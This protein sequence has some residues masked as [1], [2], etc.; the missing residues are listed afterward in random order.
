MV[1]KASTQALIRCPSCGI[2]F[3][4]NAEIT[5]RIREEA[6]KQL[7]HKVRQEL[8]E[9]TEQRVRKEFERDL[10]EKDEELAAKDKKLK[11]VEQKLRDA[12]RKAG[13]APAQEL[14]V[15]R[16]ATL[17]EVLTGRC[18]GDAFEPIASGRRG[19]DLLQRVRSSGSE[20]CGL[21]L[22][23]S[24]RGYRSWSVGWVRKLKT[25]QRREGAH[26]AVIVSDVLPPDAGSSFLPIDGVFAC[27]LNAAPYLALLLR[28]RLIEVAGVRESRAR[29]DELKGAVYDYVSGPFIDRLRG[30][31]ERVVSMKGTLDREKNAKRAEW[32]Q[33][34]GEIEGV[35]IELAGMYGDLRGIGASLPAVSDLQLPG[36]E[37]PALPTGL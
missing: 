21:I 15:I 33:R 1:G 16:Q 32:A 18:A 26:L 9:E 36:V 19:A 20:Q 28:E 8:R 4:L 27:D 10:N 23:E 17:Q 29:R 34:E 12:T 2:Q 22:W 14:G 3:P 25:D 5:A 13:Q 11:R 31:M 24:K 35:A 6:Q 30:A 7:K 37:Q